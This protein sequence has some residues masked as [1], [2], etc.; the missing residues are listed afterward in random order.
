MKKKLGN[1]KTQFSTKKAETRLAN[2]TQNNID[3]LGARDKDLLMRMDEVNAI[4]QLAHFQ[5][6]RN[7]QTYNEKEIEIDNSTLNTIG[8]R[9]VRINSNLNTTDKYNKYRFVKDNGKMMQKAVPKHKV[10]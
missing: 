7:V 8:G 3:Y 9:E 2:V 1:T 4:P 10:Q 5:R 6:G